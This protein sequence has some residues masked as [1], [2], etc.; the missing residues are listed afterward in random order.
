MDD[1]LQVRAPFV[2]FHV[3]RDADSLYLIDS[4]FVGGVG[5][6]RRA[7]RR[8][9]WDALRLRGILL[10][11]GHLDHTL[12][13]ARLAREH[14]AWIAAPWLEREHCAGR[15]PY[16]GLSR[17]CGWLEAAG[18]ALFR[19]EHFSVD[20]WLEDGDELPLAGGVQVVHLP[21]HTIGHCG[22]LLHSRRLLFVGDLCCSYF[23]GALRPPPVLNSCPG[24]IPTSLAR[25]RE[26]TLDGVLPN[27]GDSASPAVHLRRLRRLGGSR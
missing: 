16:G 23:F 26:L 8:R 21:G 19:F 25:V 5:A 2:C 20:R 6:L 11:H 27:H 18:R 17:V 7:L 24:Q 22:Y 12:N 4:G 14:G 10:T 13:A 1:V 9:G 15:Y 3:L